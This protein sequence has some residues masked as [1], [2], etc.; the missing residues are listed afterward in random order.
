MARIYRD[1]YGVPHIRATDVLDLAHGQ[2]WAAARDR[3]WQLEYQRRRATGTA[4]EVLG[5][6]QLPWDTWARQTRIVDTARRALRRAGGG[7][8]RLR[9]GVR[10]G[11]E[12]RA[13]R[14]RARS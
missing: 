13:A 14:G 12:R 10:R 11:G 2:G 7:D 9:H 1:A 8:P 6:P 4:A 3:S 5:A